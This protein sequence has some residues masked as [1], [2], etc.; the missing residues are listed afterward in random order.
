MRV[1]IEEINI[2]KLGREEAF[3]LRNEILKLSDGNI[4]LESDKYPVLYRLFELLS[5]NFINSKQGI[6]F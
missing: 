5:G 2:T 6:H 4:S 3:A 1:T